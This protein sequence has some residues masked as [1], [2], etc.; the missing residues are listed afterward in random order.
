MILDGNAAAS[1]YSEVL[2]SSCSPLRAGVADQTEP[3]SSTT[4]RRQPPTSG[5]PR[6]PQ[7]RRQRH[8]RDHVPVRRP[9]TI[10]AATTLLERK[11]DDILVATANVSA[12]DAWTKQILA[13][14]AYDDQHADVAAAAWA[15]LDA[16][17]KAD[18]VVVITVTAGDDLFIYTD[19]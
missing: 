19:D 18:T 16:E 6:R 2:R 5:R 9:Y 8:P 11:L 4:S 14:L 12:I 3:R 15:A 17:T 1:V 10:E 13:V 7:A